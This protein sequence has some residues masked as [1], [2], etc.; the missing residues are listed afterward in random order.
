MRFR[1]CVEKAS[2][3][4]DVKACEERS[5]KA[6]VNEGMRKGGHALL[7]YFCHRIFPYFLFTHCCIFKLWFVYLLCI[8]KQI[9]CLFSALF[10]GFLKSHDT[11]LL[12]KDSTVS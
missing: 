4:K 7:T 11:L 2:V 10:I 8:F 9:V 1:A 6:L 5:E 12:C 3:S